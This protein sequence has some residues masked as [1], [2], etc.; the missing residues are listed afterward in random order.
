M[1]DQPLIS[2][3]V[4]SQELVDKI[5][6][7]REGMAV[8]DQAGQKIGTVDGIYGGTSEH[9]TTVTTVATVPA[10]VANPQPAPMI[11]AVQKPIT[12]VPEFDDVLETDEEFPREM[13]ERL[14]HDGFIR[15]DAGFL[16]HHRY[17]L[18]DQLA[19][20]DAERVLLCVPH[21][22]LFKH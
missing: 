22:E 4:P 13:R 18:R 19:R 20:V 9:Q 6:M 12:H 8:F 21:N 15:I 1:I 3:A 11:E 17:A 2:P 14:M 16:H 5:A 7:V 10:A